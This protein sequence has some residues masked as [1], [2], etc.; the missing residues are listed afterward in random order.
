MRVYVEDNV[1]V[2]G[3]SWTLDELLMA[4]V[5]CSNDGDIWWGWWCFHYV[6]MY[7]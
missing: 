2:G 3:R 7:T 6:L 1:G 4:V 5:D